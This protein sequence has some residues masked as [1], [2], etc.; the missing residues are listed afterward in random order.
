M[1]VEQL[2][3]NI[4]TKKPDKVEAHVLKIIERF[5]ETNPEAIQGTREEIINETIKRLRQDTINSLKSIIV[6]EIRKSVEDE[7]GVLV[8]K[9]INDIIVSI[10]QGNYTVPVI[11]R[12]EYKFEISQNCTELVMPQL[13]VKFNEETDV[14]DVFLNGIQHLDFAI[15]KNDQGFVAKVLLTDPND[16]FMSGDSVVVR[17]L[18]LYSGR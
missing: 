4:Y 12:H 18:V 14:A 15:E 17:F 7:F 13:I 3:A 9:R 1:R 8:D 2:S 16:T 11:K 5:F 10:Y 6:S